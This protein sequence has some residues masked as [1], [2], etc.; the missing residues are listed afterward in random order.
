MP[1]VQEVLQPFFDELMELRPVDATYLGLHQHDRRL[2]QGGRA[3]AQAELRLFR[4]P[5]ERLRTVDESLD[6]EVARYFT[7]L[8]LHELENVRLGD[9]M[10]QAGDVLGTG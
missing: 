1:D 9:R 10:D 3:D 8:T 6:A 4:G 2:P 7:D 5:Q